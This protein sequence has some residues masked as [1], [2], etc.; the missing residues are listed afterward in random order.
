M[1]ENRRGKQKDL[2][3]TA[4]QLVPWQTRRD[5]V[6]ARSMSQ[7]Q[8][9]CKK[10]AKVTQSGRSRDLS[11]ALVEAYQSCGLDWTECNNEQ[12]CFHMLFRR[13]IGS[14][15]ACLTATKYFHCVCWKLSESKSSAAL[16]RLIRAKHRPERARPI[17]TY[18]LQHGHHQPTSLA[19][20]NLYY[21][22]LY[23]G[24]RPQLTVTLYNT[25]YNQLRVDIK[26][27]TS[28]LSLE[29]L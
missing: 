24:Q 6:F 25:L 11:G 12:I 15:Y 16:N 5:G 14:L 1:E 3:L 22:T 28:H 27:G 20:I 10:H 23:Y 18:I 9:A 21:L 29:K 4:A 17:P 7:P 19:L 2:Y 26:W 13:A 8:N